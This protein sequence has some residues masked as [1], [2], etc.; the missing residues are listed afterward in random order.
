MIPAAGLPHE[1]LEMLHLPHLP[2]STGGCLCCVR[3]RRSAKTMAIAV[4]QPLRNSSARIEGLFDSCSSPRNPELLEYLSAKSLKVER[5]QTR[6]DSNKFEL[7]WG[8]AVCGHPRTGGG[9]DERR[10]P[11][12]HAKRLFLLLSY[13][14]RLLGL[15]TV[16]ADLF[17]TAVFA[18]HLL[19]SETTSW[20]CWVASRSDL[21]LTFDFHGSPVQVL[22]QEA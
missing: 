1:P 13:Q 22:N 7:R 8:F 16:C 21:L 9:R 14:T 4:G 19:P 15:P 18:V 3:F 5:L 17:W 20:R 10:R 11:K 6:A 12:F 2:S